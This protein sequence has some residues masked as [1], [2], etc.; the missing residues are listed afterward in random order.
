[1]IGR[2]TERKNWEVVRHK[3]GAARLLLALPFL[4]STSCLMFPGLQWMVKIYR[5]SAL[6]L[7]E[8]YCRILPIDLSHPLR[9][10]RLR[11]S[12]L[13]RWIVE[14]R[15][16]RC[17]N[18]CISPLPMTY[19]TSRVTSSQ[20][21]LK[22]VWLCFATLVPGLE[23]AFCLLETSDGEPLHLDLYSSD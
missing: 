17:I 21:V 23:H 18:A 1:M 15:D 12:M 7:N 3:F 6:D 16:R 11:L 5:Y 10:E 19:L 2:V 22:T 8:S 14:H 13:H 20:S 9:I 4:F